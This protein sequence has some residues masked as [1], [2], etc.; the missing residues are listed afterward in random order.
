L[1][2]SLAYSALQGGSDFKSW[3]AERGPIRSEPRDESDETVTVERR[4]DELT[5]TLNRPHVRNAINSRMRD[6]LVGALEIACSDPSI[7]TVQL[8]GAG[9]NF[10]S[11]GDLDE[12]GTLP[13]ATAGHLIRTSRSPARLVA[14]SSQRVTANLHGACIGAGIELAA[15]AARVRATGDIRCQLPEL[16]FGLIPGSGGTVS[17]R[18]R[19]GRHRTAWLGIGAAVIEIE[20]AT[21][22]GL[23][24]E[25]VP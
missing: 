24:D 8:G 17:I 3:L 19:I 5:I 2:E 13:D 6:A 16:S 22:W 1:V 15:F 18:R 14:E 10:S 11:G 23:V 21:E 20:R 7:K 25:T 9:Q 12:F 4:A